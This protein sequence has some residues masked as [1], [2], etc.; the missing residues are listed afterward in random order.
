MLQCSNKD[1][2]EN[3]RN[4]EMWSEN[5][6]TT[7]SVLQ[8]N[9]ENSHLD[10]CKNT[11]ST[12]VWDHY[13]ARWRG[14]CAVWESVWP[15]QL[16]YGLKEPGDAE[17]ASLQRGLLRG[18]NFPDRLSAS[19]VCVCASLCFCVFFSFPPSSSISQ[20]HLCYFHPLRFHFSHPPISLC[21]TESYRS[22]QRPNQFSSESIPVSRGPGLLRWNYLSGYFITH[23]APA[24]CSWICTASTKHLNISFLSI[25]THPNPTRPPL[26]EVAAFFFC[27]EEAGEPRSSVSINENCF[28]EVSSFLSVLCRSL[29]PVGIHTDSGDEQGSGW[30]GGGRKEVW[31]RRD[32]RWWRRKEKL[33]YLASRS[34]GQCCCAAAAKS[35]RGSSAELF[36]SQPLPSLHPILLSAIF[37]S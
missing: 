31:G 16:Y 23:M 21:S 33:C 11:Y 20:F 37:F 19:D 30:E 34:Q 27:R 14:V 2:N 7:G 17:A 3:L 10:T 5:T 25:F 36:H 32:E 18:V 12:S 1:A 35:Y 4:T 6:E 24:F 22:S 29:Q 28:G 26:S 15:G 9:R 8:G 13:I